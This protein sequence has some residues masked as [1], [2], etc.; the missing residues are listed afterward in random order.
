MGDNDSAIKNLLI[1]EKAAVEMD[2]FI[3]ENK[4]K[5]YTSLFLNKVTSNPK[6]AFKHWP[7][8]NCNMLYTQLQHECFDGMRDMQEFKELEQRLIENR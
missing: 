4:E 5:N 7:G 1:A 2:C 8:T 6:G 3:K